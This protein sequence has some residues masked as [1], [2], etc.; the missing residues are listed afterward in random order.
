MKHKP[1]ET[2]MS[3]TIDGLRVVDAKSARKIHVTGRDITKYGVR[4]PES[5]AIAHACSRMLNVTKARVH[6]TRT[7]LKIKNKWVRYATP[8]RIRTEIIAFDRGGT[9]TPGTYTLPPVPR[10]TTRHRATGPKLKKGK[11]PRA[12]HLTVGVRERAPHATR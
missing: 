8:A 11:K 6:L 9:F 2:T 1:R 5:C 7:L 10:P 4:D 12:Y 3:K